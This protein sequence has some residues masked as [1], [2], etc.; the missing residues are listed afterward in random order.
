MVWI[1][2]DQK[3]R[4]KNKILVLVIISPSREQLTLHN[5]GIRGKR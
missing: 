5:V 3:S 1:F 4:D 2:A